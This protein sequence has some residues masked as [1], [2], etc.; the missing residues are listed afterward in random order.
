MEFFDFLSRAFGLDVEV[1]DLDVM[2]MVL[3]A[4]MAFFFTL[5]VIKGGKRRFMSKASA[6]DVVMVIILGSVISR[7]VNGSAPV[8]PTLAATMEHCD[9]RCCERGTLTEPAE[10][11]KKAGKLDERPDFSMC[12]ATAELDC[13]MLANMLGRAANARRFGE[14]IDSGI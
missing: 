10:E 5:L 1:Q 13:D 6:F 3:R 14:P 11:R 12:T 7:A 8:L 2:Q 9:A 4:C